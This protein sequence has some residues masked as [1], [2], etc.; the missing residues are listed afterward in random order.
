M[1]EKIK[2]LAK[3]EGIKN[4]TFRTSLAGGTEKSYYHFVSQELENEKPK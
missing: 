1:T 3:D 4:L 2:I